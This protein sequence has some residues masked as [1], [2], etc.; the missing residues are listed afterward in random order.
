VLRPSSIRSLTA[1]EQGQAPRRRSSISTCISARARSALDLEPGRGLTDAIENPS[2]IDGLFIERA[3]V[4]ASATLAILS[5][6]API[7]QPLLTD[8]SA[9]SSSQEEMRAAFEC[10]VVDSAAQHAR[11]ASAPDPRIL[12]RVLVTEFTLASARD[13]IRI[14]SWLKSNAP[15]S[16]VVIVANKVQPGIV[17]ISRKDFEHS[18]ER[19]S[20]SSCRSTPSRPARPPSSASRCRSGQIK[21]A[22]PGFRAA[23][24]AARA[25]CHWRGYRR[26]ERKLAARQAVQREGN[27]LQGQQE[28]GSGTDR[29]DDSSYRPPDTSSRFP[30]AIEC[31]SGARGLRSGLPITETHA[32]VRRRRAKL[33]GP[34]QG[35]AEFRNPS[36]TR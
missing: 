36:P 15:Q 28:E 23:R 25:A 18:I 5:A 24:R 35:R 32:A 26:Q 30:D 14:L 34:G 22:G 1:G 10:T 7:N 19:K 8:G 29:A 27:R 31:C 21:Q 2:R 9:S 20:T 16:Q 3:M 13:T 6:E 11:P 17:E 12:G 33:R 4:R